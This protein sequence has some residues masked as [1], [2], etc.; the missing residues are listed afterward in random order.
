MFRERSLSDQEIS[1]DHYDC[2]YA[3][4]GLFATLALRVAVLESQIYDLEDFVALF[5]F[6]G[7]NHSDDIPLSE[8]FNSLTY[9]DKDSF[10]VEETRFL[11]K[12][13]DACV[14]L[15]DEQLEADRNRARIC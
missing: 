5:D 12:F 8:F 7:K 14:R 13:N 10:T 6:S 4:Y 9:D 3:H 11:L 1:L 15:T 2:H